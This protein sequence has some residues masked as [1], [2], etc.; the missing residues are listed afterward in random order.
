MSK[1][2]GAPPELVNYI[3]HEFTPSRWIEIDQDRIN[4]FAECTEDRQFI[5]VDPSQAAKTPLGGTI[6]HG[7]LVL[8]LLAPLCVESTVVPEGCTMGLNYGFGKV[9]FLT[10][11]RSGKRIRAL[12]KV[13]DINDKEPGRLVVHHG[14]TVEIEGETKPALVAEWLIAWMGGK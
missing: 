14:V 7:F 13:L 3:G 1:I 4:A 5:H 6:A 2:T 10:P 11:V 9:R 8:S 12:V